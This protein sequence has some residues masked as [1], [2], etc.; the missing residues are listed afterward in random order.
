[1][2][3]WSGLA[4]WEFEF[5]FPGSLTS[6]FQEQVVTCSGTQKDGSLR[7]VRNGIGINEQAAVELPGIKGR[8]SL[9]ETF[10]SAYDKYLVRPSTQEC[11][12]GLP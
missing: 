12:D 9:R 10:D 6:T 7:V 1:M 5:S 4:P 3:R 2:I 8:W 11:F